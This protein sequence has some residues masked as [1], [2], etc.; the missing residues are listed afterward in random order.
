M[1]KKIALPLL[2]A[3][4]L[5]VAALPQA[6]AGDGVHRLVMQVNDNDAARMNLALNNAAN[7]DAYYKA[8]GEELVIEI[9]A[10]GPGLNMLVDGK[11]P[12][13]K[14]VTSFGQNFD[15]I[16]FVAC[17]NTLR[18]MSKK[19]TVTLLPEAK[20]TE[21]GVVH[22]MERQEQGWSYVRP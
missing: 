17:G 19:G 22:I 16:T 2:A 6:W 12:V 13:Q 10:Y 8:K 9:V 21:A 5:L 15:N 14:R 1:F 3:F 20:M 18:K 4:A 7:L 11:S